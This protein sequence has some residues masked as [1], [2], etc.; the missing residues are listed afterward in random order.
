MMKQYVLTEEEYEQL[1][2]INDVLMSV[3]F[4]IEDIAEEVKEDKHTDIEELLAKSENALSSI[5]YG[6]FDAE[7]Q[8]FDFELSK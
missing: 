6:K 3:R 8:G 1:K 2:T 4:D 7:K 5:L